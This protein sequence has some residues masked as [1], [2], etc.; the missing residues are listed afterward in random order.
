VPEGDHAEHE[1]DIDDIS[2]SFGGV[3]ALSDVSLHVDKG[4]IVGLMGP[5]GAGKSTM[6]GVVSGFVRPN[7]GEVWIGG[8]R[9]TR[10]G[11]RAFAEAGVRRTFQ[12][13]AIIEDLSVREHLMLGELARTYDHRLWLD[14]LLPARLRGQDKR[15]LAGARAQA[16]M[17]D[18]DLSWCADRRPAS[19]P[20][21]TQRIVELGMALMADP[22]V[23]LLDEPTAGLN[24]SE[25][26]RIG[27]K[28]REI[29]SKNTVAILLI[30]HDVSLMMT[31]ADKVCVLDFGKVIAHGLPDEIRRH[32]DVQTAYLGASL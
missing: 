21:A 1:L 28:L 18:L 7:R 19:L 4:E 13:A 2:V 31:V 22:S 25:R 11:P 17:A 12:R 23:L 29:A 20:P 9:L 16:L 15:E 5:N 27:E 3:K 8:K 10:R 26:A 6:V 32:P 14:G 30:E 24:R